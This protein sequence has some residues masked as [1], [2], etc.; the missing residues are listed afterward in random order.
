MAMTAGLITF[1]ADIDL[2]RL[3][4]SAAQFQLLLGK[5]LLESIHRIDYIGSTCP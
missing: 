3:K 2:K 1:A 4:G 5:L